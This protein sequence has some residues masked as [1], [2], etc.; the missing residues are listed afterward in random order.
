MMLSPHFSLAEFTASEVAA[1]RGIDNSLPDSLLPAAK[2]VCGVIGEPARA[3]LGPLHVNSGY[4]CRALNVAVGGARDSQHMRA[5]AMD[6][7][8][9]A[10]GVSVLDLLLWLKKNATFDQLI[11]EF[12]GSWCHASYSLEGPQRHQVLAAA[13]GPN[14]TAYTPLTDEQIAAL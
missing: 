7:I 4:R 6:L 14:G 5:E 1:R 2:M 13:R 11:F 8:P 10:P 12:G 3:A 9:L